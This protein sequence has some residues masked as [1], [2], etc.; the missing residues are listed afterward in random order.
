MQGA[1]NIRRTRFLPRSGH[2]L[3]Y[4]NIGHEGYKTRTGV[5]VFSHAFVTVTFNAG[6]IIHSS[7]ARR[8][9]VSTGHGYLEVSTARV[10]SESIHERSLRWADGL[11]LT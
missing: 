11:H 4:R 9:T 3:N 1:V 10:P 2:Y 5:D 6:W 8:N 7:F